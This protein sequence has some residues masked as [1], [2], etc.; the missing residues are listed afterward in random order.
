MVGESSPPLVETKQAATGLRHI[1]SKSTMLLLSTNL[2]PCP[3]RFSPLVLN[4]CHPMPSLLDTMMA[5]SP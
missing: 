1:N 4:K 2:L 3:D 5:Q